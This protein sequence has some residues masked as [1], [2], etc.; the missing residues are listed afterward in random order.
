ME[1]G[2]T[3]RPSDYDELLYDQPAALIED[4][5]QWQVLDSNRL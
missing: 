1:Q 4:G 5:R 2:F 3:L